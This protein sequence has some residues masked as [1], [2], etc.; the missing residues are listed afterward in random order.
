MIVDTSAVI[1]ILRDEPEAEA[2][3]RAI[4]NML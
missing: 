3:A 4:E 2:C 1:A